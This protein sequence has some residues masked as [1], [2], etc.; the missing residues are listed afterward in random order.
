MDDEEQRVGSGVEG[1]APGVQSLLDHV[2]SETDTVVKTHTRNASADMTP[3][4]P[5]GINPR[6]HSRA[7]SHDYKLRQPPP[8]PQRTHSIPAN[9]HSSPYKAIGTTKVGEKNLGEADVPAHK[10]EPSSLLIDIDDSS[11]TKSAR[12]ISGDVIAESSSEQGDGE[13]IE[14]TESER[15]ANEYRSRMNSQTDATAL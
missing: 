10:N 2:H 13:Q 4:Q 7:K 3:P 5:I 8:I 6:G 14:V 11:S 1:P 15:I 12:E 9:K